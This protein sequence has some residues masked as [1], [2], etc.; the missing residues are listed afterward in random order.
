MRGFTNDIRTD[1][2]TYIKELQSYLRVIERERTGYSDIPVD[3]VYGNTTAAAVRQFQQDMGLPVT[4]VV[5]RVTWEQ[6]YQ[7]Y[8]KIILE[9][10][11]PTAVYC[12]R[13]G[14]EPL[15]EGDSG[16][17]IF[18]LQIVLAAI[19]EEH[20][21]LP[22]VDTPTGTFTENTTRAVLAMQLHSGLPQ[23]GQVDKATWDAIVQLYNQL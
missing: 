19:R 13:Q 10:A 1:E 4:G 9:N 20:V 23:T 11:A 7:N 8:R 16:D 2:A 6:I 3:G 17:C 21:N 12:F 18:I 15:K 14:A 22:P 5:D